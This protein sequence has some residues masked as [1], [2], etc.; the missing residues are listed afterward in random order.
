MFK[1]ALSVNRLLVYLVLL[2]AVI[3]FIRVISLYALTPDSWLHAGVGKYILSTRTIPSHTDISYKQSAPDLMWRPQSWIA[4]ILFALMFMVDATYMPHIFVISMAALTAFAV[5][6]CLIRIHT[7]RFLRFVLMAGGLAISA[8]FWKIHPMTI[9]FPLF[10]AFMV[11]TAD[12]RKGV[13]SSLWYA[14]L[15]ILLWVNIHTVTVFIPIVYYVF[16]ILSATLF[17]K[18]GRLPFSRGALSIGSL[19]LA[20]LVS[21]VGLK[22]FHL[23]VGMVQVLQFKR[24]VASLDNIISYINLTYVRESISTVP[25]FVVVAYMT[26]LVLILFMAAV[27]DGKYFIRTYGPY[28]ISLPFLALPFLWVR[29]I[30]YMIIATLPIAATYYEHIPKKYRSLTRNALPFVLIIFM[31]FTFFYTIMPY[32]LQHAPIPTKNLDLIIKHNLPLNLLTTPEFTGYAYY[33]ITPSKLNIDLQDDIYDENETI[34]LIANTNLLTKQSLQSFISYS[35]AQTIL[36][37]KEIG[38]LATSINEQYRGAWALVNFDNNGFLFV[39]REAVSDSFLS[40]NELKYVRLAQALGSDPQHLPE[41]TAELES[42]IKRYPENVLATGQLATLYRIQKKPKEAEKLL[43]SI[44]PDQWDYVVLTEIGRLTASQGQCAAS[45][46]YYLQA[47]SDRNEQNYS[48]ATLD[49]GVLYAG[50][51]HDIPKAKHYFERYKSYVLSQ[52]EKD[53]LQKLAADFGVTLDE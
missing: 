5:N 29:F 47:L 2:F 24:A 38:N 31:S 11:V 44:P 7:S 23:L 35:G 15:I 49:L 36:A 34:G 12:A 6:A 39:N 30:P 10:A 27:R 4:N 13:R 46:Q 8:P 26:I 16:T 53:K 50:C 3:Y 9:T 28:L 19:L 52:E 43:F 18:K 42:Y 21:P 37:G 40:Q 32:R 45:E 17:S 20:S 33:R 25:Y 41:A 14:P 51:L 1:K 48:R 22:I